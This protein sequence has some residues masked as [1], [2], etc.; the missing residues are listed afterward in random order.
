[1]TAKDVAGVAEA[2]GVEFT[3]EDTDTLQKWMDED[4]LE[5]D[6]EGGNA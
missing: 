3:K 6:Q 2:F 1:M 4:T 5:S